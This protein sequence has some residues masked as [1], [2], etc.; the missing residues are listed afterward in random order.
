MGQECVQAVRAMLKGLD[1]GAYILS[2]AVPSN[3][4]LVACCAGPA[5]LSLSAALLAMLLAPFMVGDI[6][7][8][9]LVTKLV[10]DA[11]HSARLTRTA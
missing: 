1:K 6:A 4:V 3:N 11:W 5:L 9:R 10:T 7:C 2:N 8:M